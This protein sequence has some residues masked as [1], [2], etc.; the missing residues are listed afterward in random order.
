MNRE[1]MSCVSSQ[2]QNSNTI[3]GNKSLKMWKNL[4]VVE[5]Q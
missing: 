4:N 2:E 5:L 3:I 1:N